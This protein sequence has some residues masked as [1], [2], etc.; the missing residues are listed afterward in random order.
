MICNSWVVRFGLV[1][2]N[3]TTTRLPRS[4]KYEIKCLSDKNIILSDVYEVPDKNKILFYSQIKKNDKREIYVIDM[5][6]KI[7]YMTHPLTIANPLCRSNELIVYKMTIEIVSH[8]LLELDSTVSE[9]NS[10]ISFLIKG[11][12]IEEYK[13]YPDEKYDIAENLFIY[14]QNIEL[15]KLKELP[16][17][18]GKD[19]LLSK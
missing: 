15:R 14:N 4:D 19:R 5:E 7:I 13:T 6:K 17:A 3:L 10:S 1:R 9:E 8:P 12:K 16:G 18:R 2:E 11:K